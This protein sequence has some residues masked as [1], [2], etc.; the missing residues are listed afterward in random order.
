M[1]TIDDLPPEILQEVL[2]P[3]SLHD[4]VRLK[5]VCKRWNL[6]ISQMRIQRLSTGTDLEIR[7]RWYHTKQPVKPCEVC[8]FELFIV[9]HPRPILSNLKYLRLNFWVD[10]SDRQKALIFD[11]NALNAFKQLIQLEI[12]SYEAGGL[13][14]KLPNLEILSLNWNDNTN[15][16]SVDCPKLTI[17]HFSES[18]EQDQLRVENIDRIRVLDSPFLGAKLV[19]FKN[20][21]VL[22]CSA[23]DQAFPDRFALLELK[24]LRRIYCGYGFGRY[25]IGEDF[26][27]LQRRLRE[28]MRLKRVLG[29]TDLQVF[30]AG[31]L[32]IDDKLDDIDFGLESRDNV[33]FIS[34][35]QLYMKH[36]NRLQDELSFVWKVEYNRL[37]SL[38][39]VLP[40]DYF[41]R[42]PELRSVDARCPL[43]EQHLLVFLRQICFLECFSIENSDLSQSFF[44]CMPE[45]CWLF[46]LGLF[47]NDESAS[48]S[49]AK[50]E[51]QLDFSFIGKF[52]GLIFLTIE[53]DLS[54]FALRT[55]VA[56]FGHL[57]NMCEWP[58]RFRR[59]NFKVRK[60]ADSYSLANESEHL[61]GVTL[62][63]II[64][65]FERQETS[66]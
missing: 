22:H 25:D 29:R 14:L 60:E 38:V 3:L 7:H 5:S 57:K 63:E 34:P 27:H 17:L 59:K 42:F 52:R 35:E 21:E 26:D 54:L 18:A 53:R 51:L 37:F 36:Y 4:L 40:K 19:R 13:H 55:L 24:Q 45:F 8:H 49:S 46:N 10:E 9:Q 41:R 20:L 48:E 12:E 33:P 11:P 58:F 31:L 23:Y 16:V 56:A 28:F 50:P 65:Y 66:T 2:R 15:P 39:D 1:S 44:D 64:D 6:L 43:N 62:N 47:E 32:L 61:K 30:F